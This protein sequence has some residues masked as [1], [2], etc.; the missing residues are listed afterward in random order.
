MVNILEQ[1]E[2]VQPENSQAPVETP[3]QETPDNAEAKQE[4]TRQLAGR[5]NSVEDLEAGYEALNSMQGKTGQEIGELRNQL[6]QQSDQMN[7]LLENQQQQNATPATDYDKLRNDIA[8]KMDDGDLTFQDGLGQIRKI[9]AIEMQER[10]KASQQENLFAMQQQY[11]ADLQA[12]RDSKMVNDLHKANPEYA[13]LQTSGALEEIKAGNEFIN[14]DYQAYLSWQAGQ[15]FDRGK[16]EATNE[17]AGSEPAKQ[18]TSS[19][20]STIKNETPVSADRSL[21]KAE[22]F[23]SGLE[24]WNNSGG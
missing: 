19:P 11:Q 8:L 24:A 12:D 14:D 21:N 2:Q 20:G 15:A 5:F 6:T 16:N 18:V 4:E 1:D 10:S 23:Q 9:D 22:M 13:E 17:I 7:Q 3:V